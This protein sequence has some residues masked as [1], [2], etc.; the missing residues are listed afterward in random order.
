MREEITILMPVFNGQAHLQAQ[1]QSLARQS[2]LPTRL[3]ASDDGSRDDS[4]E[5]LHRFARMAPF[6]VT[7]LRGPGR[8][9]AQNIH[10]LLRVMPKGIT[11]FCDQ[12]DVWLPDRVQ[13]GRLRLQ[14]LTHP[15]LHVTGRIVTDHRLRR[16]RRLAHH[17]RPG[18]ANALVQNVA[19]ANA[20]LLSS[21][22]T[23]L[24]RCALPSAELMPPFPD[25]WIYALTTGTGGAVLCQDG[26]SLLYRQHEANLL[27]AA[28]GAKAGFRRMGYL[29]D[30]R[31]RV[32][33]RA[34]TQA[35]W[36]VRDRLDPEA[37]VLLRRFSEGLY[38][39][40]WTPGRLGIRRQG[41]AQQAAL[42]AAAR[43]GLI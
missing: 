9:Y 29:L 35:L 15:A 16:K 25:W 13:Q 43:L 18:F 1:L 12:D 33:L 34:Q 21:R 4:L 28:Q 7:V 30:G 17:P 39:R 31:Y 19:P 2:H 26:A 42:A 22:A 6:H 24:V 14:G 23:E 40:G 37:Q 11:G 20:T 3:I 8:G 32:W 10:H 36:Q 27:G 38:A 41:R 5:I